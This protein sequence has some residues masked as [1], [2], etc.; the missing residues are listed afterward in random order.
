MSVGDRVIVEGSLA[1]EESRTG[2]VRSVTMAST[3]ERLFGG[4]SEGPPS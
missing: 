4:S 3:G 1:R 2:N